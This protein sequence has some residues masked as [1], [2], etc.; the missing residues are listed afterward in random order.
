MEEIFGIIIAIIYIHIDLYK[1]WI[2]L[3]KMI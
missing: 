3:K 2:V 1:T